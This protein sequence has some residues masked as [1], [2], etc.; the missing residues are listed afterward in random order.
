MG[1][2]CVTQPKKGTVADS[3]VAKAASSASL[4]DSNNTSS[5]AGSFH[6]RSDASIDQ[7]SRVAM[8]TATTTTMVHIG[9]QQDTSCPILQLNGRSLSHEQAV[10]R[11][12]WLSAANVRI[13]ELRLSSPTSERRRRA[14]VVHVIEE[15]P[16]IKCSPRPPLSGGDDDLD[17][18]AMFEPPDDF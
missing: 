15:P 6:T 8:D 2:H 12:A 13:S 3:Y 7:G 18:D 11:S 9:A 17:V 10:P 5:N 1:Q 16:S 14:C 4:T